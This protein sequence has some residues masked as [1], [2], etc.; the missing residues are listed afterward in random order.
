MVPSMRM[1]LTCGESEEVGDRVEG[2]C[3]LSRIGTL[4]VLERLKKYLNHV[5]GALNV[6]QWHRTIRP[7]AIWSDAH[8]R[9]TAYDASEH[10]PGPPFLLAHLHLTVPRLLSSMRSS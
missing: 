2:V 8:P 4:S 10:C 5:Q 1:G 6:E 3:S 9:F 7:I